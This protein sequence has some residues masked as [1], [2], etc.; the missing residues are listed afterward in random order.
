MSFA[1][2]TQ[3]TPKQK[4]LTPEQVKLQ[5]DLL[6]VIEGALPT[7]DKVG[8]V[9]RRLDSVDKN[10]KGIYINVKALTANAHKLVDY[11]LTMSMQNDSLRSKV[12]TLIEEAAIAKKERFQAEVA[13]R[14]QELI[15]Q[16]ELKDNREQDNIYNIFISIGILLTVFTNIYYRRKVFA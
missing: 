8:R 11:G 3:D 6:K 7:Y 9:Y 13:K 4:K 1:G 12:N 15:T 10:V 5:R 16:R 14:K 2:R